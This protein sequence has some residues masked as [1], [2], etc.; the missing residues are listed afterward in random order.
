M[1]LYQKGGFTPPLVSELSY[2]D[3]DP[4]M[5]NYYKYNTKLTPEEEKQFQRWLYKHGR[6]VQ[7]NVSSI[8]MDQGTYDIRGF[9]KNNEKTIGGHG[10]DTY[11]KP[12]HPTFSNES[13]HASDENPGGVWN[14]A[15]Y[16]PTEQTLKLYGKK[17]LNEVLT[18]EK[19]RPEYLDMD[20]Y[21][22]Y[23]AE[24]EKQEPVPRKKKG[25]LF[26]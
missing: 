7:R 11:K 20:G 21:R 23:R 5:L 17:R 6:D 4:E 1:L 9:W 8:K 3:Q 25:G 19:G 10:P 14:G 16:Q 18:W 15:G 26:Y 12:N 22:N 13:I 24:N 2:I